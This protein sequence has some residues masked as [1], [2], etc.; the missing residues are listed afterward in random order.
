MLPKQTDKSFDHR[1][2]LFDTGDYERRRIYKTDK[3]TSNSKRFAI[4]GKKGTWKRQSLNAVLCKRHTIL[5]N[6]INGLITGT[7][8]AMLR[9]LGI[10]KSEV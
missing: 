5:R 1:T 3:N 9:Q 10:D 7:Y 6:P 4:P 2:L 8:H